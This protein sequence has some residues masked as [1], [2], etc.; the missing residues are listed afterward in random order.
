MKEFEIVQDAVVPEHK[1][2][3]VLLRHKSTGAEI[4]SMQVPSEAG[5]DEKVFGIAF[6]T[7]PEDSSGVAHVLEHSVLCGSRNYPIKE[8]FAELLRGSLQT[9]LNAMT[10]PDRT[11]YPVASMN[12]RDFYNLVGVYLDAV[13]FPRLGPHVLQQEGWRF[14]GGKGGEVATGEMEMGMEEGL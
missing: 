3:A 13:F 12:T 5:G 2:H 4:M 9:F 8:P 10:Y 7:P 6:A 1:A 11:V 14:E